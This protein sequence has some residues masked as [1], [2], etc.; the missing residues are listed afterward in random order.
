M[1]V[2]VVAFLFSM[3]FWPF[4]LSMD[5]EAVVVYGSQ[6]IL[7]GEWP[8]RDWDTH[9][10]PG[11]FLL[12][13]AWFA[14]VGFHA[15]TTRMLFSCVFALSAVCIDGAARR[16][17][18]RGWDYLPVFLWCSG[19]VM[20]F[21]I[22]SY[23][24]LASA[25][26]VATLWAGLI[27]VAQPTPRRAFLLGACLAGA[28]W[29][30]QSEGLVC[31]LMV[32]FWWLR[33]RPKHVGWVL[34]G[35]VLVSLLLWL[36]VIQ[37]W[38][39]VVAQNVGLGKHLS[40]NRKPYSWANLAFFMQHYQDLSWDQGIVPALARGSHAAINGFR[41]LSFPWLIV[42]TWATCERGKDKPGIVL[43]LALLAWALGTA[44][45]HTL[46]YVSFLNPGWVVLLS[47][48]LQKLPRGAVL[49]GALALAELVGWTSRWYLR[50]RAFV[51]P[52]STR[53]G[54][55]YAADPFEARGQSR[56]FGWLNELPPQTD[57]LAF[58]YATRL[59]TLGQLHNPTRHQT[60]LPLLDPPSIFEETQ[61]CLVKKQVQWLVYL[62]PIASEI[63][64]DIGIPAA[65][66]EAEWEKMR[67]QMTDG[68]QLVR[69]TV[70]GGLYQRIFPGGSQTRKQ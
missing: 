47:K 65:R 51:Y 36:P 46:L 50:Q 66:V 42:L 64:G 7:L 41:Y 48:G 40:F 37:Q 55:Y 28:G 45:R 56:L 63:E 16:C 67:V 69:G 34:A 5:D 29:F 21:P 43:A 18:P 39:Q 32:L 8:Y 44:N 24:W 49:G 38:P 30:L 59:Y 3:E 58:P 20:D 1:A 68:Y 19:G 62:G 13:A 14:V 15:P 4:Y 35:C 2:W 70:R 17:L 23:H 31:T 53:S 22:L 10:S 54:V 11:S 33:F 61:R 60:L 9:L 26:A 6:R 25:M 27:W 52:I 12:G 57:V